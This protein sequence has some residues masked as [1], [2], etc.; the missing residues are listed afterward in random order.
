MADNEFQ[1]ESMGEIYAQALI[2]E[3][4]K[5]GALEEVSED[6]RGIGELL[7]TNKTFLAFTQSLTV[8][9][10]ERLAALYKIFAGRVHRLTLNVIKSMARRD[11]LMFLRGLVE[12][13]MA[14]RKKMGGHVDVEVISAT[15][16]RPEVL[17][18]V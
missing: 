9:E 5:Q 3:A 11:R 13:F 7:K 10:E 4:Q 17:E 18:R 14:I 1:V 8:G 6:V 16:I 15:E 2:N 12:G